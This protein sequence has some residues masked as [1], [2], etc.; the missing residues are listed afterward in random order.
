MALVGIGAHGGIAVGVN[1]QMLAVRRNHVA[2]NRVFRNVS[3]INL[4]V[5]DAASICHVSKV[6]ELALTQA[7]CAAPCPER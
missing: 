2:D 5:V 7:F 4:S 1:G 6:P 3:S